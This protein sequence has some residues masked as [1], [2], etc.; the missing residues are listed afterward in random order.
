MKK[1]ILIVDDEL[2]HRQMLNAVLSDEGYEVREADDGE[3]AISAVEEQFHDLVI[4]D[5]RMSRV[6]GIEAL[7]RIKE[8]SPG[9]P[10]ILMTAYASV[11]TAIDALKKGAYDYLTKPLDIDEL[12]ILVDKA[13]HHHQLEQENLF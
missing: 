12:K 4:M 1:K 9:I 10:I 11:G 3:T 2:A 6:G 13:L 5:I 7:E 8:I